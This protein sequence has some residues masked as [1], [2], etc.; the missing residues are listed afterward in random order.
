MT[1]V[2]DEPL[3]PNPTDHRTPAT[4]LHVALGI[5]TFLLLTAVIGAG[6]LYVTVRHPS[7][8]GPLSVATGGI[9]LIF[10]IAG[11]LVTVM[12]TSRR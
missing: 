4:A 9:A 5:F 2:R 8:A 3:P 11:V 10:T 12:A 7:L 1:S 6:L